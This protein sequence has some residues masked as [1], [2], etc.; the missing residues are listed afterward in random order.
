MNFKNF[1]AEYSIKYSSVQYES[2]DLMRPLRGDD[3]GI[4]CC[5]SPMKIGKEM[6]FFGARANLAKTLL[7]AI[8]GGIDEL[9][10]DYQMGPKL[11]QLDIKKPLKYTEIFNRFKT[12]IS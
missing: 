8:N 5:V 2:D 10:S 3:Y 11:E 9:H 6:Q 12:F 1:C 7:Y 4:A